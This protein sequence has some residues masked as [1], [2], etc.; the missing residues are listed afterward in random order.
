MIMV[1]HK[2]PHFLIDVSYVGSLSK[3]D[4]SRA[5]IDLLIVGMAIERLDAN[6]FDM[7]TSIS[8]RGDTLTT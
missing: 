5:I 7:V 3:G 1:K 2:A 8:R 4:K 6:V